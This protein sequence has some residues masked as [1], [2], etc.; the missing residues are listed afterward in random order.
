MFIPLEKKPDWRHPPFVTFFLILSVTLCFIFLQGDDALFE[1]E[2]RQYYFS[3]GLADLEMPY[4]LSYLQD[5]EKSPFS[6]TSYPELS[7]SEQQKLYQLSVTDGDFQKQ[8]IG[9]QHLTEEHKDYQQWRTFRYNYSRYLKRISTFKYGYQPSQPSFI[10]TFS[11]L[12]LHADYVHLI[13]NIIFLFLFGFTLELTIGRIG[14]LVSFLTAGAFANLLTSVITPSNAQWIVGVSGAI[15]GLAGIYIVLYGMQ[16]IRFFYT[17]IFYFDYVRAPAIILLPVWLT[18]E[19]FYNLAFP[20]NSSTVTHI[21]G[22]V[23]GLILGF[24]IKLSTLSKQTHQ[25]AQTTNQEFETQ[26]HHGMRHIANLE[27]DEAKITFNNLLSQQ[28]DNIS[29]LKQLFV[30]AKLQSDGSD[31]KT[32][33]KAILKFKCDNNTCTKIQNDIFLDYFELTPENLDLEPAIIAQAAA[34]LFK[35]GK[36]QDFEEV[37]QHMLDQTPHEKHL[38]RLLS[39]LIIYLHK[40]EEK[41][42]AENYQKIL[43]ENYPD[44]EETASIKSLLKL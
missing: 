40:N 1:Q 30:V 2:A 17:V 3:S 24:L 39:S 10:T 22:L 23:S 16:R 32:H 29:I 15:T 20:G 12:F 38:P 11:S 14:L 6:N 35:S 28:P 21:G 27:F 43:L 9:H 34:R 26:F 25:P 13:G 5:N 19:L 31:L 8:L 36:M 18:Y 4:Y 33:A 7:F 37:L 44:S 41:K 42:R